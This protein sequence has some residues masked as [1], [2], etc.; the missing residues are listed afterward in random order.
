MSL[1]DLDPEL[2]ACVPAPEAAAA[3]RDTVV[4]TIALPAGRWIADAREPDPAHMGYLLVD[5][6]MTRELR[7]AGGRSVE[8]LGGGDVVR[9]WQED[10]AS[11]CQSRMQA[12]APTRLA[13]LDERFAQHVATWPRLAVT[14]VDRALRRSRS[15]AA[16][17][18]VAHTGGL[19]QRLVALLWCLAERWGT[20]SHEGV[21]VALPLTHQTLADL[22]GAQRPS[23]TTAVGRLARAGRVTRPQGVWVLHGDPPGLGAT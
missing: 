9:P 23:V 17:S 16:M 14:L 11:F 1:L 3:R 8:L 13:V 5:G 7:A 18:A 22:V 6:L 4:R 21:S 10:S 15:L 20:V 2:A 19:E 12:F